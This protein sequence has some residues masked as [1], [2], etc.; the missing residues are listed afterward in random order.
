MSSKLRHYKKLEKLLD[1]EE[2]AECE[3]VNA[4]AVEGANGGAGIGD[5]RFTKEI[6]AGVDEDG[7]GSGFAEFV[8]QAPEAG[9]GF[10][11]DGVNADGIAVE[12]ETF[13]TRDR[14][15]ERA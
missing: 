5:E 12:S 10:L 13:E 1:D 14:I 9:V 4:S 11:F 6:E 8:Q 15:F 7:R 3:G 2:R